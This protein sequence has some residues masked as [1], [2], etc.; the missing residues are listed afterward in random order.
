VNLCLNLKYLLPAVEI[1]GSFK[2][3][4]E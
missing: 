2:Q 1:A 3:F 4:A